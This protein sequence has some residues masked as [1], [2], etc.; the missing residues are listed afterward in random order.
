MFLFKKRQRVYYKKNIFLRS[1]A[2][3][4]CKEAIEKSA[5]SS[6]TA[7]DT[8]RTRVEGRFRARAGA[9]YQ[10]TDTE[11]SSRRLSVSTRTTGNKQAQLRDNRDN[12]PPRRP[13]PRLRFAQMPRKDAF[14]GNQVRLHIP[15][16][17]QL[18]PSRFPLK[19]TSGSTPRR[20]GRIVAICT[21][22]PSKRN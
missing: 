1:T 10:K 3:T 11:T 8:A 16:A 21:A 15:P 19:L 18:V 20:P 4:R 17:R 9:R 2:I 12:R 13:H 22:R 6:L 5:Q 14:N 7:C